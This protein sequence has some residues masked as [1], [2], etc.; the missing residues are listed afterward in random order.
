MDRTYLD[1]E[2]IELV[3]FVHHKDHLMVPNERK[4]W[5]NG[6]IYL[7]AALI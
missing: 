5:E 1:N 7:S 6:K 3:Q 2:I 4:A